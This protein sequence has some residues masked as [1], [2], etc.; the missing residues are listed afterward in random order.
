[1]NKT[2]LASALAASALFTAGSAA[3][4]PFIINTALNGI[5]SG[6]DSLITATGS[7]VVTAQVTLG[8]SV[9][10]YID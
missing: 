7:T 9:Y 3:A 1:M 6:F 10:N 5:S 8:Q 4:A 2:L